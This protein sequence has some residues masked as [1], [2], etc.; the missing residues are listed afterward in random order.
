MSKAQVIHKMGPPS[1]MQW[2]DWASLAKD[3]RPQSVEAM[4]DLGR[5]GPRKGMEEFTEST[6]ICRDWA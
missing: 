6:Y 3:L 2:Q 4:L 1:I 5:D